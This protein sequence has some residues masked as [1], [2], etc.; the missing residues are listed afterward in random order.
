MLVEVCSL[1]E[2][3]KLKVRESTKVQSAARLG[4]L[5]KAAKAPL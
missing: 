3:E 1:Q 4:S 2:K 5:G